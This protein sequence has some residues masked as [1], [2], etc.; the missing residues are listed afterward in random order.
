MLEILFCSVT[1]IVVTNSARVILKNQKKMKNVQFH[2]PDCQSVAVCP[3]I[4]LQLKWDCAGQ[5]L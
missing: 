1:V 5:V 4:S 2:K 3:V